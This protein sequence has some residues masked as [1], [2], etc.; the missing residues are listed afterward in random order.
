MCSGTDCAGMCAQGQCYYE[1]QQR[2]LDHMDERDEDCWNCGGEGYVAN[3]Q[4]EIA[5]LYPEDGCELCM[6]RCE[7]CNPP[8][9]SADTHP[10]G[11][12]MQ[13]APLV[14]GA[15]PNEDSG[16]AR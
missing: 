3:C 8:K 1:E 4:D 14:S 15:V 10:K 2:W 9:A 6:Q 12:D 5:C 16:D 7:Y 11:G 13:Q